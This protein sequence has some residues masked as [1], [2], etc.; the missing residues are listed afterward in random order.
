MLSFRWDT[1]V[2][3]PGDK[4]WVENLVNNQVGTTRGNNYKPGR[5]DT[6]VKIQGEITWV[7]WTT[8]ASGT[9]QEGQSRGGQPRGG[10][11]RGI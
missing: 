4:S 9:T 1:Q 8:L 5:V 10:Q 11:P 7:G 2:G 3:Q 6:L